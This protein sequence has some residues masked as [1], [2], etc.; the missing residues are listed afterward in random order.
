MPPGIMCRQ[1]V[2][3]TPETPVARARARASPPPPLFSPIPGRPAIPAPESPGV[4][5]LPPLQL[6]APDAQGAAQAPLT[7]KHAQQVVLTYSV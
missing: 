1:E 3:C 4:A 2:P 7:D 6:P 5:P